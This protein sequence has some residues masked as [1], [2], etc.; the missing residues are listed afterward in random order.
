MGNQL[1]FSV[2]LALVVHAVL[3]K[4]V[5]IS[6]NFRHTVQ[7][8]TDMCLQWWTPTL[9][10]VTFMFLSGWFALGGSFSE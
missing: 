3:P 1:T 4:V 7:E 8:L 6:A 10:H 9:R 5:V 2:L